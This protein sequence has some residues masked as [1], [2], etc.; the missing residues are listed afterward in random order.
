MAK[1]KRYGKYQYYRKRISSEDR[2]RH[3]T[4][5]GRTRAERDAKVDA[6]KAAW[7]LEDAAQNLCRFHGL[8]RVVWAQDWLVQ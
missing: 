5:Y 6:Q 3:A 2:T 4:I 8:S 1:E 7:A